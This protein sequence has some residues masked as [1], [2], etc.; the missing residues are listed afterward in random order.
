MDATT[1]TARRIR[2]A[3]RSGDLSAAEATEVS[4]AAI[5]HLDPTIKAFLARDP[6]GARRR[7]ARLDRRRN[8][9]APLGL[10]AGVP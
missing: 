1:L 8:A 6:A 10:L 5:E 7:A 4:L 3:F 2:D 9:G